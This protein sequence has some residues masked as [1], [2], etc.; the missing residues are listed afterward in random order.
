M[1]HNIEYLQ[2]ASMVF[3]ELKVSAYQEVYNLVWPTKY[4]P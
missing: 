4:Q 3:K 1:F 2:N